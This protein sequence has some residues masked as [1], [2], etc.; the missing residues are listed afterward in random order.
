MFRTLKASPLLSLTIILSLAVGLGSNTVIFSWLESALLRPLPTVTAPVLSLETKDDTGNYVTA[1]WLEYRDLV[2]LAPA[3]EHIAFQRPKTYHLGDSQRDARVWAQLVS[4]NF[5]ATLGV[6]PQLGRFFHPDETARPGSAPVVVISHEFWQNHFRG[7]PDILG[8]T[9]RLNHVDLT[10]VGVAAPGFRGGMN[11][12]GFDAWLPF[13]LAPTLTPAATDLTER[14]TRTGVMLARLRPGVT[15]SQARAELERAARHLVATHPETNR[16]LRYELLPLWRIPRGGEA[17]VV[18]L[19]T[20]QVF[21]ILILIV[22]CANTANLLLARATTRQRE[23]G[24]RLALGASPARILAQLLAESI[25]LALLGA[26]LGILLAL[27]GVDA[28]KQ[29]PVPGGF[30]VRIAPELD[31]SA[32]AFATGLGTACGL[33]F[34][35]APALQLARADV[36]TAL[37]GTG[38][39]GSIGG[40]SRLRDALVGLQVALALVVLVLAGLFLKS[41][42]NS[43]AAHPGFDRDRVMLAAIDLGGRGYTP[44]TGAT[45]LAQLLDRLRENPAVAGASAAA[46]VPLDL[47]GLPVGVISVAGH[48]FD[49]ERKTTYYGTTDGYLATL[50][51][52][53]LA[54]RDLAPLARTDLP[55]DA[56]INEEMARRYWPDVSPLGRR[57]EVNGHT[58]EI[59]G[60]ARTT[61]LHTLQETPRPAAYLTLRAGFVL[62]PTLHLRPAH[63]DPRA[64][65]PALRAT[66]RQFDAELAL[67]DPRTLSQHLDNNLVLQRIPAQ[68]LSVLGPLALALPAIGLYAILAYSLAQRIQE[69]GVRL[70]LGATPRGVVALMMWQHLRVV[71]V[72]AAV[73]WLIA[74]ALGYVLKPH[75]I[76]VPFLDPAIY[77]GAPTLLLLVAA[78]ACYLPARRAAQVDPMIAL[79]AE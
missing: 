47:R 12:L 14:T 79:R 33:A 30:P 49:P 52:P 53:L 38:A 21:A 15:E 66:L 61:K 46:M 18:S 57:F 43:L 42:R 4:A 22:V 64:L 37:R 13:T 48:P 41:F 7:A 27:W 75:F 19:A 26:G 73:G 6:Q 63:G 72:S 74:A 45:F 78:L 36:L 35:L 77:L 39:R 11:A 31:L 16:G 40:R 25:L 55:F 58:F 8:R 34:G 32:L 67:L 65:L 1:S 24:V 44:Q 9:L 10:I 17:A 3:F 68:L 60:I 69:I 2:E 59:V 76:A 56:V 20:L 50:G 23:I 54:G 71:I 51:I 28:I 70:T 29:L 5:F 62:S